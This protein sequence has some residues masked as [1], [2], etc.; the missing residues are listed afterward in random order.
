MAR[1]ARQPTVSCGLTSEYGGLFGWFGSAFP[2][3]DCAIP[4]G[5]GEPSAV[6]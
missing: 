1:A 4:G 5:A 3:L 6:R 2:E